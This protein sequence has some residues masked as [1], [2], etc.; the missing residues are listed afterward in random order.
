MELS[1]HVRNMELALEVEKEQV[2]VVLIW[3][4]P[5]WKWA[6]RQDLLV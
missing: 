3:T 5:D 4:Q 2:C 6:D 1:E